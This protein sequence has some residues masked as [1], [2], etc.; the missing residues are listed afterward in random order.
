MPTRTFD[1]QIMDSNQTKTHDKWQGRAFKAWAIV[2]A[3][4]IVA[5]IIYV[6]QIIWQAVAVI[7]VTLLAVFLLHGIVDRL[8]NHHIP[9]WAGTTIAFAGVTVIII[10]CV[11]ALIPALA[12][13]LTSFVNQL[14]SYTTQ[15]QEI[16]RNIS[17]RVTFIDSSTINT[18]LQ[19]FTSFVREQAGSVASALANGVI[20]GL[21]SVGNVVLVAFIS[22]IC[23]FWILLDLPIL[24]REIRSLI[25]EKYQD[26]VDV[27]ASAFGTAVYGWAKSTLLCALITGIASWLVFLLLGIPY[28]A[29]LGFLCGVLYFIPYIGPMVSCAI[30]A[31]IALFVSPITCILSIVINVIINNIVGNIISPRLMKSSVNVYPAL[32]LIAILIG[33]ALGGIA[34]MLLSIPVIGALQGVFV[35]Y[36]EAH[37]GK[38]LS[39]EDGV[40]FHLQKEKKLPKLNLDIS[41]GNEPEE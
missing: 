41:K 30:V 6:C 31:I 3:C 40:L 27:I 10:G 13:Q 5:I 8:E 20:G 12:T 34:G 1:W 14:P 33:S 9:R 4:I 26:D 17:I 21:V 25:S 23:S 2:G 28:S 32:I 18:L 38:T 7:I 11:V 19:N 37:T 35:T 15:L 29:V 16:V 39:T 22:F 36:Y 24:I